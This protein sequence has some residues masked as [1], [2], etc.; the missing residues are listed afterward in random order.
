MMVSLSL[1]I[2]LFL[3]VLL[4]DCK[5]KKNFDFEV[6]FLRENLIILSKKCETKYSYFATPP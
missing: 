5:G 2:S 4:I 3:G 6:H 1:M